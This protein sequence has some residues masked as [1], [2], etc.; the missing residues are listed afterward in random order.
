MKWSTWLARLGSL[1]YHASLDMALAVTSM[2]PQT[3]T[4]AVSVKEAEAGLW[5]AF[6]IFREKLNCIIQQKLTKYCFIL[7]T[8][9]HHKD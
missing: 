7:D 8:K 3:Y 1:L 4:T 2:V 6:S 5:F 9:S